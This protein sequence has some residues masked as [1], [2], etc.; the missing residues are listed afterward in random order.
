MSII[1]L[2]KLQVLDVTSVSMSS[3]GRAA[4][5]LLNVALLP[6]PLP[7]VAPVAALLAVLAVVGLLG[8]YR[9]TGGPECS[10]VFA[11]AGKFLGSLSLSKM[12]RAAWVATAVA[13]AADVAAVA[14]VGAAA[15]AVVVTAA[16]FAAVVAAKL[17]V[18]ELVVEVGCTGAVAAA[19]PAVW[20]H[21]TQCTWDVS[22]WQNHIWAV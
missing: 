14:A 3:P 9:C 8:M 7:P 16:L 10:L 19:A 2:A 15:A 20:C 12:L 18:V 4:A 1:V 6:L 17:A 5:V 22:L 11:A 21:R 13:A